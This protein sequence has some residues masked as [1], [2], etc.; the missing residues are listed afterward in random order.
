MDMVAFTYVLLTL[1]V[2]FVCEEISAVDTDEI[3]ED[4]D[5]LVFDVACCPCI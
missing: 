4:C 2:V 1:G 3:V 5:V